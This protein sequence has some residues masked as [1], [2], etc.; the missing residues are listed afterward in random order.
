MTEVHKK[1]AEI[2]WARLETGSQ[3]A[4]GGTGDLTFREVTG[5]V[6]AENF[7]GL[8]FFLKELQRENSSS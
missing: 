3:Q 2:D 8:D 5:G 1:A 6:Q 7:H 4:T